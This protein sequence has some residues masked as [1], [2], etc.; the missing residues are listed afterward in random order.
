MACCLAGLPLLA[1]VQASWVGPTMAISLVVIAL[2]FAVIAAVVAMAGRKAADAAEGLRGEVAEI[3]REVRPA[4]EGVRA[5]A[6]SGRG[7]AE[8]V[9]NE[10][11]E[12]IRTSQR[13]R[14]DV[15]RGV[16][17]ARRRLQDFDAVV[18]VVQEEVEETAL[19]VAATLRT[20]RRGKGM[21]GRIRRLIRGRR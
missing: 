19:D 17:K 18:E 11:G 21:I 5:M 8:R 13:V 9:E 7:I 10:V 3:R 12:V 15:E 2:A 1:I 20:V 14:H 16:R 6:D 4:V